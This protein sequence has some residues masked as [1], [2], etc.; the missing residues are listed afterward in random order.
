MRVY[1]FLLKIQF[2][3]TYCNFHLLPP[4]LRLVQRLERVRLRILI[5]SCLYWSSC[6]RQMYPGQSLIEWPTSRS[7]ITIGKQWRVTELR[8]S[9]QGSIRSHT[10]FRGADAKAEA[11]GPQGRHTMFSQ[12]C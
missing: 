5:A 1:S 11:P 7:R 8:S 12:A 2:L 3:L 9:D 10:S 6:N 4:L